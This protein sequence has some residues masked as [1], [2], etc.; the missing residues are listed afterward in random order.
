MNLK[1]DYTSQYKKQPLANMAAKI[2]LIIYLF[3]N[4]SLCVNNGILLSTQG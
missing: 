4:K 1:Y 2:F 3:N